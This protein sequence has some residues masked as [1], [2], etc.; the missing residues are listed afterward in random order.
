MSFPNFSNP[1]PYAKI[2]KRKEIKNFLNDLYQR[3]KKI[4]GNIFRSIGH[5]NHEYLL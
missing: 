4:K 2:S 5:V 3:N 1:C